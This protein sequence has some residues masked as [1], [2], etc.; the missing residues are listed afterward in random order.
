MT[1]QMCL[2][3]VLFLFQGTVKM[4]SPVEGLPHPP[5]DREVI[6]SSVSVRVCSW[7]Y[8]NTYLVDEFLRAP[9]TKNHKH[10]GL[11]Q[12]KWIVSQ[13]WRLEA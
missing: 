10:D 9:V 13:F 3:K 4:A 8:Y 5:Q 6:S 1:S 2:A 11:E 7:L 12:Q